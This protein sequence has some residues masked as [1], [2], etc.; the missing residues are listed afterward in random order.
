MN[1]WY[2]E[3]WKEN[4]KIIILHIFLTVIIIPLEIAIF[5]VF[6]KKLFQ[7]L[8]K[9]DF[10]VFVRMFIIF[11]ILLSILQV[12]YG[13]KEYIDN[14]ITPRV[15]KFIRN[16]YM[17]R[18]ISIT[19]DSFNN[20]DVMNQIS[21]MPKNFYQNY[22]ALLKFWIPLFTCFLFYLI[23]LYWNDIKVG[24]I[25]TFVFGMLLA[26]FV[27][28]FK[29]LT[30]YSNRVFSNQQFLIYEYEN[31]LQN[32]E[33][34]QSYNSYQEELQYLEGREKYYEK[35]RVRLVFYID[36]VKFSF[37]IIVFAYMLS[38]FFYFYS[39]MIRDKKLYPPWKF[40][41]F[42]T[43][44]FF[45]V[46]FIL[47]LMT[48]YQKTIQVN[49]TIQEL[50]KIPLGFDSSTFPSELNFQTYNIEMKNITFSYPNKPDKVILKNFNL[51]IPYRSNLLIKGKIGSGKSTIGRLLCG[52]YKVNDGEI[53]IDGKNINTMSLRNLK[54]IIF[55]I[56]Q[57]TILFSGK[58]VFENICYQYK[59]LPPKNIL[60]KYNLPKEFKEILDV[61]ITHQGKNVSGGQK[62]MVHI[63]RSIL[64]SAPIV[65][66]DEPTDS[67]DD[68]ITTNVKNLI[69]ELKIKKTVICI[70]HDERLHEIFD[71]IFK[72]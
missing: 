6:T 15:Q 48:H 35:E 21:S 58:T 10:K 23:F 1:E 30:A 22:E 25:S 43:I 59:K 50:S 54:S 2:C 62:R 61:K 40:I 64:H 11:I 72:I 46:R 8:Q 26:T 70:S 18:Y 7:S 32:S 16:R 36:V 52:W 5:S 34:I 14:Q 27:I 66:L 45:V 41:T 53:T 60:D 56:S 29:S 44:L 65:I 42:I 31:I 3:F 4:K 47:C 19:G 57:N 12:I 24:I 33:T 63:L 71:R 17:N 51:N 55:M 69:L 68:T 9:N 49:G 28:I 37:T 67:L 13:W 20:S 39:L 38:I